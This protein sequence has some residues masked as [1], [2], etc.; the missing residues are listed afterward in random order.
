MYILTGKALGV[1]GRKVISASS[2][3][4]CQRIECFLHL[5]MIVSYSH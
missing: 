5:R 2:I 4:I 1:N 3:D